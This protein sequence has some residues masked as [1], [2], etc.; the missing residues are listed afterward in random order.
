MPK[1][2]Y[3][4][5]TRDYETSGRSFPKIYK[6]DKGHDTIGIGHKV[7]ANDRKSGRFN[8]PLTMEQQLALYNE[9]RAKILDRFYGR[10][11]T[12]KEYPEEVRTGLEDVAFNVGPDFLDKFTDMKAALDKR[13]F[14]TAATELLQGS[15]PGTDSKYLGD[16][17][18]RAYANAMRI[19]DGY[20]SVFAKQQPQE[21]YYAQEQLP[22]TNV[23]QPA[24]KPSNILVPQQSAFAA[25]NGWQY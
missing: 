16:V 25:N 21:V 6:D 13:D 17:K 22:Q 24:K 19:A 3:G 2:K 12:Y 7:T 8:K 20:N 4:K 18:D 9:D 10:H 5:S 15:K 14:P 11:P 1:S 23:I